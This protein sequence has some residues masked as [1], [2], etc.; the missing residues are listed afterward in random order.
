MKE[1]KFKFK[2][3]KYKPPKEKVYTEDQ[4]FGDDELF[5]ELYF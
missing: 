1:I 4:L 5:N 2:Y 3:G